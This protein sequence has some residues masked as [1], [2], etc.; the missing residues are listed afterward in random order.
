M[1]SNT[2]NVRVFIH[3]ETNRDLSQTAYL[4]AMQCDYLMNGLLWKHCIILLN[5]SIMYTLFRFFFVCAFALI[6]LI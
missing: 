3:I 2:E 4:F 5:I 1:L 6:S